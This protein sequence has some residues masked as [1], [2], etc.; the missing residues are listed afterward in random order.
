MDNLPQF[1]ERYPVYY[2]VNTDV[3]SGAG[4]HWIL[5]VILNVN[6]C[7]EWFDSLGHD[8]QYYHEN[9][10]NFVTCK[11]KSADVKNSFDVQSKNSNRCGYFCMYVSDKRCMGMCYVDIMRTFDENNLVSND[12]IV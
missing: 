3:S 11:G 6:I 10:Q 1:S 8:P 9:S 5:I 12:E 2:I 7:I 4:I